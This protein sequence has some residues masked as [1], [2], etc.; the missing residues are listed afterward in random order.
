MKVA[1]AAVLIGW[2]IRSGALDFGALGVFFRKPWLLAF[3]LCVFALSVATATLRWRALLAIPGVRAPLAR[4]AQLQLTAIFFNVVIPGN[5]GGDV[6]K[7]LYVARDAAPEKRTTILLIVFVERLLGLA[8]LVAVASMVTLVRGQTL[9]ADPLLRPIAGAVLLLGAGVIV[10]PAVFVLVM[11]RAGHHLERWIGGTTKIGKILAQLVAAMRLLAS[12]PKNLA[13]AMLLSMAQH[14][15]AIGLFTVLTRVVTDQDVAYSAVATVFPLGLL[16]LILPI[17]PGGL[18]VGH[19][20]F[21]RL[22]A[23]IG[24]RGGATVFNVYLLGQ[25]VPSLLGAIPYL[26]LRRKGELP[27]NEPVEQPAALP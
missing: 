9:F 19:V 1:V 15:F 4:L 18:G 8:G 20:A 13:Y 5:V 16:T 14:A 22:F 26:A 25:M 2:L 6:V 10:G 21:D 12:S 27:A 7:A 17:S 24:L 3:D 11:H 23:A